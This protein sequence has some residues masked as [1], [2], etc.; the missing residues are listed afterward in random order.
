MRTWRNVQYCWEVHVEV[1]LSKK[2]TD[3]LI[4]SVKYIVEYIVES[5]RRRYIVLS[6][7]II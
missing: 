7:M 6:L 3:P 2:I 1:A 4:M 5:G